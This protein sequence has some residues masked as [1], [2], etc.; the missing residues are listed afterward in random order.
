MAVIYAS[1]NE[2]AV[3][4]MLIINSS[5][6]DYLPNLVLLLYGVYTVPTS[7]KQVFRAI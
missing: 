5:Y 2:G 7:R 1:D 6:T 3:K 4:T